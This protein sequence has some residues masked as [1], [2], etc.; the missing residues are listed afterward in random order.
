MY[1]FRR[2]ELNNSIKLINESGL[3]VLKKRHEIVDISEKNSVQ[4]HKKMSKI[5]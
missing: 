4:I 3:V 1:L 2:L 5:L